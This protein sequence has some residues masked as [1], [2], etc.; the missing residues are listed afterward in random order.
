MQHLDLISQLTTAVNSVLADNINLY[1][2]IYITFAMI[3]LYKFSFFDW[4]FDKVI[5]KTKYQDICYFCFSFWLSM[6]FIRFGIK[7]VIIS[8]IISRYLFVQTLGI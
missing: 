1:H 6:V 4:W 2:G 8:T 5:T 7:D 3:I